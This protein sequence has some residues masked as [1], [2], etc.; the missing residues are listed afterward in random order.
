MFSFISKKCP[1]CH[2]MEPIINTL[3]IYCVGRQVNFVTYEINS[4]TNRYLINEFHLVGVPT[5]IFLN[6]QGIEVS[7]LVGKQPEKELLQA[8]SMARGET[9]PEIGQLPTSDTSMK[10]F[11]ANKTNYATE[12]LSCHDPTN[13][14]S[15]SCLLS[16][17]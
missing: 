9:C 13:I 3:K 11:D 10:S 6:D 12:N 5:F 8:L 4:P 7:R 15:I 2:D 16:L 14:K 17:P 1:V